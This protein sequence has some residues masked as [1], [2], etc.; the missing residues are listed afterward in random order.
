[1]TASFI[2]N[3]KKMFTIQSLLL[4]LLLV[5]L[6]LFFTQKIYFTN[7]DLGRH[8]KNGEICLK[9]GFPISTNYYSYTES[10]FPVINHHWGSGV[11]FYLV[12]KLFS[13]S[14]LT[15]L[16]I[17]L[18]I[19][20]FLIFFSVAVRK[21][22]IYIAL[23]FGILAIPLIGFRVEIR[24]E[25]FSLLFLGIYYYVLNRFE[26]R[27]TSFKLMMFIL[28]P[29]Q[30]IWC[31][32]HLFFAMGFFLA[33]IY[34]VS[35]VFQKNKN[36][37]YYFFLLI[38]LVCVSVLNPYGFKGV[39][40]P[41][42]IL[43][44][45]GYTIAENMSVIFMQK[46]FPNN[47]YYLYFELLFIVL[48][49]SFIFRVRQT[50]KIAPLILNLLLIAFFSIL[51]WKAIRGIPLFGLFFLPIISGNIFLILQSKTEKT[52]KAFQK[53]SVVFSVVLLATAFCLPR[54]YCSPFKGYNG[55]GL[56]SGV[57]QAAVFFKNNHLSGPI[58]N[59]YDIGGYLIYHL[60]PGEKVFVDN[61]PEAYSVA[62]FNELYNPMLEEDAKWSQI[63][64][65][66]DFNCIFFYRHDSTPHGQPFLIKR[67]KDPRWVP[68]FVDYYNIILLKRNNRNRKIIN[69]Y[70]LP[71]SMFSI[72]KNE[73]I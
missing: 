64:Q 65:K 13:F 31:N 48:V 18:K 17:T 4:I 19:V 56:F 68:V 26:D 15:I 66:Y 8:I 43:R 49:L 30:I 59:N 34:W 55:T 37:K 40:E 12:W 7:A 54:T 9:N 25:V 10:N 50:K 11:I 69:K 71:N 6:A 35:G 44:E 5:Y 3:F 51:S 38:G 73:K 58:F 60:F 63:D 29:L 20:T 70:Q 2:Q 39:F 41:F 72:K 45:Y 67:I 21:S 27:K 1:M 24:P 23:L 14:G 28:L 62:F 33:G 46:R 16:N 22:N 52:K 61:R 42:L 47:F 57:N 32:L 53:V 36:A